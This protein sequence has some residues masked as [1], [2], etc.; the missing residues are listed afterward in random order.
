MNMSKNQLQINFKFT[1]YQNKDNIYT[2]KDIIHAK[3]VF[4]THSLSPPATV[5]TPI[6]TESNWK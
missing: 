3:N 2:N 6:G 5:T 1:N 4:K